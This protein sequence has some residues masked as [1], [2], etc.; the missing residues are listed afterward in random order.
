[1]RVLPRH[2]GRSS[3]LLPRLRARVHGRPALVGALVVAFIAGTLALAPGATAGNSG[4][5]SSSKWTGV[6]AG[7]PVPGEGLPP[8][9]VPGLAAAHPQGVYDTKPEYEGQL[10][11]DPQAK[12]GTQRLADHIKATYGPDQTVWIPRACDIGGQSEHKEGR[13][14]D[15]MTS[16]RDAQ[17]R[18]NAET[19]LNWLLGPDQ[20]G[21]EYGNAMRLGVMYIGWN[22][23]IWRGYD[24]GRG[25]T[26]LKG[27]FSKPESGADTVCHRNHIH[28][29]LTW[30]GASGRSS[31][32][33][34]VPF[35]G[36]FCARHSSGAT[37]PDVSAKG[38]LISVSPYT[39]LDTRNTVGVQKRCRLQQDRWSGDS[40]RLFP[41]VLGQNGVPND[42]VGA[43]AV[44]ITALGSNANADVR[45]W[46][47]GQNSSKVALKVPMNG[48]AQADAVVPVANDGTIALATSLGATD[49]VVEV[50][51]YYKAGPG[52]GSNK[53][54]LTGSGSSPAAPPTVTDPAPGATQSQP[55]DGQESFNAIG[56]DVAY[57]SVASGGPL[58]PGEAR[59]VDLAGL[60]PEATSALVVL[61]TR[62]STVKGSLLMSRSGKATNVASGPVAKFSFPKERVK[63]SVMLVPVGSG[64]LTFTTSKESAVDVK[65]ELLGYSAATIPP[66]AV[67]TTPREILKG[68]FDAG[69]SQNLKVAGKSGLPGKKK[70]RAVLLQVTTK[71]GTVDGKVV[72][73]AA[74]GTAPSTRSAPI[75]PNVVRSEI[76]LA[77]TNAEGEIT[78]SATAGAKVVI[79]LIGYVR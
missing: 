67:G 72:A 49:L 19:F 71:K 32:W 44:H 28:I 35:D 18:A 30:D 58:Q 51:G 62:N 11:C 53:P 31:F 54:V 68:T 6:L 78:I 15:W 75:V 8:A 79:D 1:M 29:S 24:I 48:D 63:S 70:L 3:A 74:N 56:S 7:A 26:E 43:V 46:S 2:R 25:W 16:V 9:A 10:V 42:G 36:G 40:H 5:W 69:E 41:K 22:D 4:N 33:S 37:T 17:Q 12:P 13:A 64:K 66:K 27:C 23:R 47:P 39:V 61:T 65:V 45:V 20:Y 60:P 77:Q 50:R 57:D 73:Y 34:G 55:T 76:V 59:T 21:V 38:D 14:I 52:D